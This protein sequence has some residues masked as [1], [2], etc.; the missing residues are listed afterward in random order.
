MEVPGLS[1]EMSNGGC[2]GGSGDKPKTLLFTKVAAP[3]DVSHLFPK[4]G[5]QTHSGLTS[6]QSLE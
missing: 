3:F 1:N 5:K 4:R 6:Y 2:R